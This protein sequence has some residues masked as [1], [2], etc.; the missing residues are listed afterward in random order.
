[1]KK[2]ELFQTSSLY[3]AFIHSDDVPPEVT[4]IS[5]LKGE[6]VSYQ[7]VYRTC[8][9]PKYED[10]IR[11]DAKI[12]VESELKDII[13]VRKVGNVPV[14]LAAYDRRP[15]GI[16]ENYL[17]TA[18][19]LYPDPLYE[20][21][22]D[23]LEIIPSYTNTCAL[24]ISV[25]TT[26]DT[27]SGSYPISIRIH[28]E[29]EAVDEQVVM[30]LEVINA[31]LPKQETVVTQWFHTDCLMSYYGME[32]FSQ[33][34]WN[35]VEEF[36]KTAADNGLNMILT[37]I[38]TPPL[39]TEVGRERPTVQ[40]VDIS[41]KDEIYS[42]GFDK[43]DRWV[44]ICNRNGIQYLEMAHLFSQWGAKFTPKVVVY[45]NGEYIK[46]FGWH[47]QATSEGYVR[48]LNQFL[49]ALTGH[50]KEIGVAD[51]TFFH[52]SDEPH[53]PDRESYSAARAI[54]APLLKDFPIIDAF[55]DIMLYK[56]G[57]VD[58]PIV[59]MYKIDNF[60]E[61]N[62]SDLWIYYC[63]SH[64]VDVSNR[65]MAMPSSR[66]RVIGYQMYKFGIAGFLQW[67]YNF[68]FSQ[69]SRCPINPFVTTD[70]RGAFPA[71]DAFS[72]YPGA[73]KAIESLRLKVFKEALQDIRAMKL[74]EQYMSK[75]EIVAIIEE[76][77]G[78]AID[79]RK[80]PRG[81]AF[82]LNTRERI[83]RL[84]QEKVNA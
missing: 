80:Y 22:E 36:I 4:G 61:N 29:Q 45:E 39:D 67:G 72:V 7:I 18:P 57:L 84:I 21:E 38:V 19:G 52:V 16:D 48:F 2:L 35:I 25:K 28:S 64:T 77:A 83:N 66:N 8:Y 59:G 62:V 73:D 81:D 79:F 6:E 23:V 27:P 58:K 3:K 54:V 15:L 70:A 5:C 41:C 42:F 78:M 82:V 37:P 51:R 50:L 76:E 53:A 12:I 33:R 43:L 65:L 69:F 34:Y 9:Q 26:E 1:M 74:L 31:V 55:S 10:E 75:E 49:P 14:E 60:L 17:S 20:F 24:W 47:T 63:C 32:V 46:K 11:F 30:N 44:D 56:E 13:T 71:G 40:L 68:Y